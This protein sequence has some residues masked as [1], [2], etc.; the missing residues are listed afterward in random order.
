MCWRNG[1]RHWRAAQRGWR[2]HQGGLRAAINA[3]TKAV[4]TETLGNP[5]LDIADIEQLAS[6]A[7]EHGVPLIVDN[8]S[9]S[10]ALVRPI[11]WGADIVLN[12]ATKF[13]GGH[14]TSIGGVIVDAGKFNWVS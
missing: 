6:I 1:W 11:E 13:L 4:Y 7:H 5:K 10:A 8:T 3:K 12:S 14:G 2:R 9:A